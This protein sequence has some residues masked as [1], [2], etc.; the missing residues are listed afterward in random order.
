MKLVVD[1]NVLF[2][3]FKKDSTTRNIITSYEIFQLYTPEFCLKELE[4]LKNVICKK[5]RISEKEF[6]EIF[7]ILKVFV[8]PVPLEKYKKFLN[9]AKTISPDPDDIDIFAL[10]IKLNC[11]IWSNDSRL[12]KQKKIKVFSTEEIVELVGITSTL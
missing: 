5:A 9:K 4:K 1:T 6:K 8:M 10:A 2:S 7:E 3:F 12:K 11:A